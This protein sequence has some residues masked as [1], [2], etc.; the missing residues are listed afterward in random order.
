MGKGGICPVSCLNKDAREKP[1]SALVHLVLFSVQVCFSGWHVL[2][3]VALNDGVNA[4]ALAMAREVCATIL[5]FII[6]RRVDGAVS[7]DPAHAIRFFWM[8]FASCGNVVGCILALRSLNPMAFGVMQPSIPV[9]AML[10]SYMLGLEQMSQLKCLGVFIS[11][12]GAVWVELFASTSDWAVAESTEAVAAA[13][14]AAEGGGAPSG[15]GV[16]S[17]ADGAGSGWLG[18]LILLWQQCGSMAA[19]MV[20]QKPM[21]AVYPPATLTAW[22]YAVGSALTMVVCGFFGVRPADFLLTG[23]WEPWI[24]LVYAVVV[25]TVYTYNAYSW[26]LNIVSTTTA[27]TYLTLQPVTTVILSVVF[28]NTTVRGHEVCG[29]I[30][31]AVGLLVT[32]YAKGLERR[33]SNNLLRAKQNRELSRVFKTPRRHRFRKSVANGGA[34]AV[35]GTSGDLSNSD[36]DGAGMGFDDSD[37]DPLLGSI[38]AAGAGAA[39]GRGR[40]GSYDP[41]EAARPDGSLRRF[42][43]LV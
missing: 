13:V 27:T 35:A 14:E 4:V 24:A 9:L 15:D 12:A 10:L 26:V 34:G 39:G 40:G 17:G 22:Y 42:L 20:L 1:N 43:A 16:G 38:S 25:G 37:Q 19:L 41:R 32:I 5:M 21:L 23:Q 7:L 33:G 28:L 18:S 11:V 2:A 29:G 6:A 3:K 8:G 36:T 30:V 31:I